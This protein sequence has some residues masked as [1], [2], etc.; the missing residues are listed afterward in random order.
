MADTL[1][2][3][4]RDLG[5]PA[6]DES[7]EWAQ[8]PSVSPLPVDVPP[9]P[10]GTRG[11]MSSRPLDSP[12][13]YHVAPQ[14][15]MLGDEATDFDIYRGGRLS[16]TPI[17]VSAPQPPDIDEQSLASSSSSSSLNVGRRLGALATVVEAAITRWARTHSSASSSSSSSSSSNSSDS[18]TTRTHVTRPRKGRRYSSFATVHNAAYE[19][20]ILARKKAREEFRVSPREFTLLLPM[21]L[22]PGLSHLS[23]ASE[24]GPRSAETRRQAKERRIIKT[25]SMPLILAQLDSALKK[26]AK[27]RRTQERTAILDASLTS[28][29]CKGKSK[30]V[31]ATGEASA[32][33]RPPSTLPRAAEVPTTEKG[34]WLDVASPSWDDLRAIGKVNLFDFGLQEG[35][36]D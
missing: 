14:E 31:N 18:A 27:W 10:H 1:A 28:T 9:I 19:R 2:R 16:P 35:G 5:G 32:A 13:N 33:P 20:A 8:S 36:K 29:A 17:H 4:E 25:T 24:S 7:P 6:Y 22:V 11:Y 21:E 3:S 26:S 12:A 30:K 34:W 15:G 23:P